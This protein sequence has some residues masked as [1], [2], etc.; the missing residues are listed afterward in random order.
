MPIKLL[1]K[2]D[3]MSAVLQ[4]YFIRSKSSFL[5]PIISFYFVRIFITRLLRRIHFASNFN[6][7]SPDINFLNLGS[8]TVVKVCHGH[9]CNWVL[10]HP[11]FLDWFVSFLRSF[12]QLHCLYF[13]LYSSNSRE[14]FYTDHDA[15]TTSAW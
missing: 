13:F 11:L 3:H 2:Q 1:R 9:I 5:F 8:S 4:T 15:D 10:D 7:L 14:H 6:L 12:L